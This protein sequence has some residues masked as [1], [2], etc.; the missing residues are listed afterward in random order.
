MRNKI[1]PESFSLET[2]EIVLW[3]PQI[4]FRLEKRAVSGCY[5][6][7]LA[8]EFHL[9]S[10]GTFPMLFSGNYYIIL[11]KKS[12]FI[13]LYYFMIQPLVAVETD[14]E[15]DSSYGPVGKHSD[16]YGH[17]TEALEAD[18]IYAKAES[19]C[20]HGNAGCNH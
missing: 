1:P 19:E 17:W 4:I 5:S 3:L 6:N 11:E 8:Q 2:I 14:S 15:D 12:Q 13:L 16:P 18:E 9:S 7:G 20:P 10:C